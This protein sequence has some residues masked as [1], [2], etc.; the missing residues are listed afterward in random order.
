MQPNNYFLQPAS[1][2][3][4]QYE[5][6]RAFFLEGLPAIQAAA[7]FHYTLS[8]FYSL[9]R[10]FKAA[11]SLP[12][13]DPFFPTKKAGRI[14]KDATGELQALILSLRKKYLSVPDITSALQALGY[15]LSEK[16]VYNVLTA[17][18]FERLPRRNLHAKRQACSTVTLAAPKAECLDFI[19]E[20]FTSQNTLGALCLLP[21]AHQ[22]GLPKLLQSSAYPETKTLDK[23]TSILCFVALKLS[24]ARR[25]TADDAWCMDRGLGL[26]AGLNVL[27]KAAWFSSYSHRITPEMN[28]AFLKDLNSLWRQHG[29]LADTANLDFTTIPYWGDDSHL[30]NNWSATRHKG[31]ASLLAVIGQDPHSGILTYGDTT[32]RHEGE[33]DVAL[34]FLDFSRKSGH[35]DL[36]YLV[37]DS[38]FTSYQTLAKLDPHVYFITIRRRGKNIVEQVDQLPSAE[39]KTVRVMKADG[40]GRSLRVNDSRVVLRGYG[41]EIRQIALTGHGKLKP[42]LIITNDFEKPLQDIIRIYARRW[43]VEKTISEQ[44]EFF[45]LNSVSSSMVI[46]VDFDLTMSIFTQNILR[47]FALD[48]PGYSHLTAQSLFDRFLNTSGSVEIADKQ[49]T[50][51]LKKK[52]NLPAILTAMSPFQNIPLTLLKGRTLRFEGETRS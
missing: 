27:P 41:K 38:R 18:G 52:R 26:F 29:L 13:E 15:H 34:Q 21:Y 30:E 10:D 35:S 45:H 48:L 46:K 7:K 51:R 40:K 20:Q 8:T 39:W 5:A 6:L 16:Y 4:R 33:A 37:F 2:P 32:T 49:I 44:I 31:L 1:V 50:V 19:P 25:Y 14:P 22:L 3:Q 9:I 43:L 42:A 17:D 24:N 47:L 36:R 28:L 12:G 11:L 23:V